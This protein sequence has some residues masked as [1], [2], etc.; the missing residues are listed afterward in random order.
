MTGRALVVRAE[1]Q[2]L[3]FCFIN[4]YAPNQ[5]SDRLD[6]FQKIKD[7]LKQCYQSHCVVMGEDCDCTTYFTLDRTGEEPHLQS[8][9]TLSRVIS[10]V[11]PERVQ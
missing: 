9:T 11:V 4:I 8:S 10:S 5:G 6:I 2:G 3:S 7:F 1:I